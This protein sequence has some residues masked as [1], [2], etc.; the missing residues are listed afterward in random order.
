MGRRWCT[1]GLSRRGKKTHIQFHTR[2]DFDKIEN[3]VNNICRNIM[4]VDV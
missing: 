2:T 4:K 1:E 3:F